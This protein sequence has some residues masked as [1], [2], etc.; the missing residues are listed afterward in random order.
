M[1]SE[2]SSNEQPT[3]STKSA[4][5]TSIEE[6]VQRVAASTVRLGLLVLG[7]IILLFATGQVVGIDLLAIMSDALD[8]HEARWFTVAFFGLLLIAIALRGFGTNS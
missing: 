7:V 6:P 4:E 3:T 5:E 1:D 2:D 8:T